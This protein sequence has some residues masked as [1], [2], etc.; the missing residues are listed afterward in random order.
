[1]ILLGNGDGSFQTHVEYS[2]GGTNP[3]GITVTDVD[4]D[5]IADLAIANFGSANVAILYGTGAGTFGTPNLLT[6]GTNPNG[7][8][9]AYFNADGVIDLAVVNEGSDTVTFIPG[10]DGHTFG[11]A[12]PFSTN[13]A[14]SGHQPLSVAAAD[15]NG[16][17]KLDIITANSASDTVSVLIG[18]GSGGFA[19]AAL[20]STGAGTGPGFVAIGD[21][22][23]DGNP[24]IVTANGNTPDVSVLP[25]SAAGAFG[26]ATSYGT[27]TTGTSKG[28]SV[29]VSDFNNNGRSDL[30]VSNFNNNTISVLLGLAH[31]TTTLT[32]SVNPTTFGGSTT[33][34]ATVAPSI[35]TGNV[36]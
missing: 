27:G 11:A 36:T 28:F 8:A 18:N 29:A 5:G 34:T 19:Q 14:G 6:V 30:V 25:G 4:G 23:G 7:I 31:T 12:T 16:D 2:T 17:G 24:D 15:V 33:F 32:S 10:V 35:V 22:D 1:S 13:G 20:Y 26:T 9:A 3:S 21:F